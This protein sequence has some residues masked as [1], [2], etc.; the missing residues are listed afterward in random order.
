VTLYQSLEQDAVDELR[1]KVRALRKPQVRILVLEPEGPERRQL[2]RA[3]R[4]IV[5]NVETAETVDTPIND[6]DVVLANPDALGDRLAAFLE[7]TAAADAPT[8]V[9]IATADSKALPELFAARRVK[10]L[11]G[12]SAG[13]VEPRELVVTLLK[14]LDAN[15]FGI[16]KYFGWGV[17]PSVWVVTSSHEKDAVVAEGERF[18]VELG[19]NPRI[20]LLV[21][22][23]LDELI[24]NAVYNAP[25]NPDGTARYAALPRNVAVGLEPHEH[26]TIEMVCDGA[27]I[28]ICAADNFGAITSDQILEY[29]AKGF[30][31]GANRAEEK[32]GGA[33]LGLFQ[34]YRAMSSFAVNVRAGHRTEFIGLIDCVATFR[35]LAQRAKSFNLFVSD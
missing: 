7:R 21:A 18:A 22:S 12:R 26:V 19:L 29:M 30:Q 25:R 34:I 23:S 35:E 17:S 16:D 3:V 4:A 32:S 13:K 20:A 24:T 9:W 10:C 14:L 31:R 5:E 1:A 27:R 33:G 8:V 6:F 2:V 15:V 11:L 28:G